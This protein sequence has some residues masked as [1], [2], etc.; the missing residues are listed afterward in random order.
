MPFPTFHNQTKLITVSSNHLS[1]HG[2][3]SALW[4]MLLMLPK[5]HKLTNQGNDE[6]VA[7]RTQ[8]IGDINRKDC[9]ASKQ[10]CYRFTTS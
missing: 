2:T 8:R 3:Q 1:V 4:K 10:S 5:A 6:P 9:V 7:H